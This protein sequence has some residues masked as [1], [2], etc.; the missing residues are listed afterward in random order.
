MEDSGS[1]ELLPAN[2]HLGAHCVECHAG[3]GARHRAGRLG[4]QAEAGAAR[5]LQEAK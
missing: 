2:P 5:S 3:R 4:A 1:R